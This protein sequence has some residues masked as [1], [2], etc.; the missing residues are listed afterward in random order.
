[1]PSVATFRHDSLDHKEPSIRLIQLLF[2]LSPDGLTQCT[3]SHTT[4]KATYTCL[5]YR[6][7]E[8]TPSDVI[9][10][11]NK[12]FIV[13]Q[14]LLAFLRMARENDKGRNVYWI[15]ALCIDQTN[16][17][18]RNHQ[19]AQMGRIFSGAACVYVWLGA[20]AELLRVLHALVQ[21]REKPGHS[22]EQERF[23]S[24]EISAL[25]TYM[26]A[27]PYWR[28]AWIVQEKLLARAV[29][30]WLDSNSMSLENPDCDF[31][32]WSKTMT[33]KFFGANLRSVF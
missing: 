32:G 26:F 27:N 31:F 33:G 8:P 7:G 20:N 13:R 10:I 6:W 17:A 24:S 29:M 3:I 16:T 12:R 22:P 11:N 9:L 18:E 15:D 5:S 28:R 2:E 25:E 14:N 4:I 30:V 21:Y 1:M 19:V 23:I